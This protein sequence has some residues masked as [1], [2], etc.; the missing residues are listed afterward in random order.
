MAL[1]Y[2][3]GRLIIL[4]NNNYQHLNINRPIIH[5]VSPAGNYTQIKDHCDK[6][7][8]LLS[9]LIKYFVNKIILLIFIQSMS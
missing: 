9:Y 3:E 1:K 6:S 8:S 7:K 4:N 2:K 5:R